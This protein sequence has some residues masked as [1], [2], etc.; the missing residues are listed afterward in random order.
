MGKP[1][2]LLLV[3]DYESGSAGTIVDHIRAFTKYSTNQYHVLSTVEDLPDELSLD[4]FD[5]VILHYTLVACLDHFVSPRMRRRIKEFSGLKV[6]FVQDDYR[7]IN[8]TV[9]ALAYMKIDVLFAL[10]GKDIIDTVYSPLKLPGVRRETV[11]TGYVPEGLTRIEVAPY[12]ERPIDVGY[13]ARKVPMWIGSH[14]LQ[15]WQI[16]DRFLR[17]APAFGLKVDI[18]YREEDRIY[19]D[20]WIRFLANCKSALGTESGASVCDFSGEIQRHVEAHVAAEPE[21]AFEELRDLYFK[22]VDCQVI[23]NVISPRCFEAAALRTLM[24]M[25]EGHY[26]GAL[27]PWKHYVP[28]AH[29]HSNMAEVVAVLRDPARAQEI[30]DAA[31]RDVALNPQYS[32]R[33]MVAFVDKV[34]G[35]CFRSGMTARDVPYAKEE[36]QRL[37]A[38]CKRRRFVRRSVTPAIYGAVNR[39]LRLVGWLGGR[40]IRVTRLIR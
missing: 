27:L 15:K 32:F 26:S 24:I 35:E 23:M 11:L 39:L 9:N 30:I 5:G 6:A 7:W 38:Q 20:A 10:A 22:D 19:G 29:D 4:K 14:T 34:L 21:V 31:Y 17:D 8:D 37:E 2:Q 3:C 18:S 13:R 28:L 16:A 25:Y 33:G 36:W 40:L 12:K 1:L